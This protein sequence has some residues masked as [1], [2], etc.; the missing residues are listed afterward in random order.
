MHEPVRQFKAEFFRAL[1]HPARLKIL[2]A[3]RSGEKSVSE[4]QAYVELE[5]A[6]VSQ[7]LAVL[8][9]KSIVATRKVGTMVYYEV[10][11]PLIFE[12]LEVA[13]R[14]FNNSLIDTQAMLA[15]LSQ[16]PAPP[17]KRHNSH[18]A[19]TRTRQ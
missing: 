19:K 10:R 11:D 9:S 17:K 1:G 8:R 4:L 12:L 16:E 14:I 7:Q 2:D 15:E 3:L 6:A 5:P 18:P 13:R